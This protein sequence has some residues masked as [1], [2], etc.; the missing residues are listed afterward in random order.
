[1]SP[2]EQG[3]RPCVV[4]VFVSLA[5]V[6]Y[7]SHAPPLPFAESSVKIP[8]QQAPSNEMERLVD[9]LCP[10]TELSRNF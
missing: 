1:M 10:N 6:E 9:V 2:G 8:E 5:T 3:L 4:P 7:I